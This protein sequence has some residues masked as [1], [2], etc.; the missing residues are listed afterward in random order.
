MATTTA[1]ESRSAPLV[2]RDRH[3]P[4][5]WIVTG[6]VRNV[7]G[8]GALYCADINPQDWRGFVATI[9]SCDHIPRGITREEAEANARLIAAAPDMLTALETIALHAPSLDTAGIRELTD[10]AIAKTTGAK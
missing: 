3:T 6:E 9:Q 7:Q 4:G 5:P 2:I 8:G 1:S 10:A